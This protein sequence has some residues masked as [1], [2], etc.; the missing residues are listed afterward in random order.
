MC[1]WTRASFEHVGCWMF[2]MEKVCTY[3]CFSFLL[4]AGVQ[5]EDRC[6]DQVA[7]QAWSRH[8]PQ[9]GSWTTYGWRQV[10]V[11]RLSNLFYL[12]W[13][14]DLCTYL[15]SMW[16]AC[17]YLHFFC[18]SVPH[19]TW[20]ELH[21]L[22]CPKDNLQ[23]DRDPRNNSGHQRGRKKHSQLLPAQ[24]HHIGKMPN[25]FMIVTSILVHP[26]PRGTIL[27]VLNQLCQQP[28]ILLKHGATRRWDL[29]RPKLPSRKTQ[30]I[31]RDL[32]TIHWEVCNIQI[33]KS[34]TFL[35]WYMH[36]SSFE[37]P[38]VYPHLP[39]VRGPRVCWLRMRRY[40]VPKPGGEV[41]CSSEVLRLWKNDSIL[42]NQV[43]NKHAILKL[44][45]LFQIFCYLLLPELLP[46]P[47]LCHTVPQGEKLRDVLMKCDGDWNLVET[48]VK[49]WSSKVKSE[50]KGGAWITKHQLKETHHWSKTGPQF[51]YSDGVSKPYICV[52]SACNIHIIH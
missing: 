19:V 10:V 35:I 30:L 8:G 27:R 45:G 6:V 29:P 15:T 18:A 11:T 4:A 38:F 50:N 36:R 7:G 44:A 1:V 14:H 20:Q 2:I 12:R 48:T 13:D 3:I 5:F 28:G 46:C 49:R 17:K 37:F 9:S 43:S 22:Q 52:G 42:S 26:P 24:R 25:R 41:K 31:G 34:H 47:M 51:F 23:L 39:S 21:R 32:D 33:F 16:H 40:C